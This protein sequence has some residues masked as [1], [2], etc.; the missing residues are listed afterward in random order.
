MI[1]IKKE[2][3]NS[4]IS[5]LFIFQFGFLQP[6]ASLVNTQLP[7]A[8][9]SLILMVLSLVNNGFKIK[10]HVYYTLI[11]LTIFFFGNALFMTDRGP[12]ILL[13]YIE[14]FFKCF[15]AYIIG[16][17]PMNSKHLFNAFKYISVLN[18]IS[19]ASYPFVSFFDSMNYMRFGYA[20]LPSVI[21]FY[22][23]MKKEGWTFFYFSLLIISFSIMALFGSRGP[24]VAIFIVV[25]IELYFNYKLTF[26]YKVFITTLVFITTKIILETDLLLRLFDV[27][28]EKWGGA[29][30][31]LL[32]F[33]T[34]I[35]FGLAQA[36]SGRDLIYS[37]LLDLF[38][39]K[40][41]F[42]LGIGASQYYIDIGAHN[43]ILQILVETGLIGLL[44]WLGIFMKVFQRYR[45]VSII[46]D[47]NLL[48]IINM[49]IAITFGRLL[50]S[51]DL[52]L[53]PELWFLISLM[54]S[55][56]IKNKSYTKSTRFN[57]I[58]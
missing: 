2:I 5:A 43:F 11:I 23:V 31:T 56:K 8:V 39:E 42:G 58:I 12:S 15:S 37:N 10:I 25:I 1:N 24:L 34:T 36:S 44:L 16:S 30:Y 4:Y 26:L 6:L 50:V 55:I 20:L 22:Y 27:F 18:F 53:R 51:S 47:Y 14:F 38:K 32:K 28:Y 7:I 3:Y 54:F 33:R 17:M 41:V 49:L 21:M 19:I 52:W 9:F 13:L 40:P 29:S 48:H 35:E 46:S 45:L 57:L